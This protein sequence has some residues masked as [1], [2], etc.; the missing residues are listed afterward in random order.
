M[1]NIARVTV[2]MIFLAGCATPGPSI[3]ETGADHARVQGLGRFTTLVV[4]RKSTPTDYDLS[5]FDAKAAEAC[6]IHGKTPTDALSVRALDA[7]DIE[8]LYA[9]Q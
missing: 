6:A 7:Y 5:E 9:C 3:S 4:G 1:Q 2:V 8:V